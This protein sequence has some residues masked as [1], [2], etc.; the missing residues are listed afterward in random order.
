MTRTDIEKLIEDEYDEITDI[1]KKECNRLEKDDH[2]SRYYFDD[3]HV[4]S[5]SKG[6]SVYSTLAEEGYDLDNNILS[7]SDETII[8]SDYQVS[9]LS[10]EDDSM[11]WKN[12][13]DSSFVY[14]EKDV[15]FIEPDCPCHVIKK[16]NLFVATSVFKYTEQYLSQNGRVWGTLV[17]NSSTI[18]VHIH[19]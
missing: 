8:D 10:F 9:Y 15:E 5:N 19:L 4:L 16:D 3:F 14:I 11:I 13:S 7:N 18:G 17:P 1:L 12:F 6:C 2:Q